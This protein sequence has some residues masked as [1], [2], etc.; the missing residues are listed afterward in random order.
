MGVVKDEAGREQTECGDAETAGARPMAL[1]VEC[2]G[3]P[4]ARST[5]PGSATSRAVPTG[6]VEGY[7]EVG[8][9]PASVGRV[10]ANPTR[11]PVRQTTG[12]PARILSESRGCGI[13]VRGHAE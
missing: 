9:E 10:D 5:S 2:C 12:R 8:P 7:G 11:L 4:K 1:V 3:I 13:W 6:G